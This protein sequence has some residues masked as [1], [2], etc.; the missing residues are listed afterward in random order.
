VKGISDMNKNFRPPE[1]GVSKALSD[2]GLRAGIAKRVVG[3]LARAVADPDRLRELWHRLQEYESYDQLQSATAAPRKTFAARAAA[4]IPFPLLV[5]ANCG[6]F[7]LEGDEWHCLLPFNCFGIARHEDRL[8]VGASAGIYSFVLSAEIVGNERID[9][10][11]N[12]KVLAR[13]EARY[14]TDRIHQI[15]Y[16]PKAGLI[17]CANCR[18]NSLL[19]VGPNGK[20]IVDEK[21]PFVDPRGGSPYFTNQNNLNA[22]MVNGDAVLF[23]CL[24]SGDGSALGFIANDIVH[25]YQYPASGA[26][27]VV[28]H[29][30]AI[31]FTDSFRGSMGVTNALSGAIRFRGKEYLSQAIDPGSRKL[32]LR[33][34]AIH[35]DTLIVGISA[36]SP[37]REGRMKAEG[38]GIIVFRGEKL[39]SDI[40]GPFSQV[41]DILPADGARTDIPGPARSV[42][43]LDA[44]FRRDVGPLLFEGPLIRN[45]RIPP[46]R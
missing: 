42:A 19:A 12:V 44:M 1:S 2:L 8:F 34:L 33:G 18:R 17:H 11:R 7:L 31:M 22:V 14:H 37:T 36:N 15:A 27:D 46:L 5:T 10:L 6:L 23:T 38:G 4:S 45:I 41:R 28:I 32:V 20:G 13:Y 24:F 40:E 29:D 39:I 30:D 16:D 35:G 9:G 21:F 25:V 43:E 3:G 26:H